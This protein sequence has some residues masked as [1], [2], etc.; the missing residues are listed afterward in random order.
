ML[1]L[2]RF[3]G[4]VVV[5]GGAL[6]SMPALAQDAQ[7]YL[8]RGHQDWYSKG[9]DRLG[10]RQQLHHQSFGIG[11]RNQNVRRHAEGQSVKLAMPHKVGDRFGLC[12]PLDQLPHGSPLLLGEGVP[13]AGEQ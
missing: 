6:A 3:I 7:V 10:E 4:A 9:I 1:V 2:G 8:I 11:P 12:P 5:A 13:A